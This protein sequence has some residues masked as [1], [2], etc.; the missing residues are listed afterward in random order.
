MKL[1][2]RQK[3]VDGELNHVLV[4][5]G[6]EFQRFTC[7][8]AALAALVMA[9]ACSGCQTMERHPVATAVVVGLAAGSI[10]ASTNHRTP[11]PTS[12]LCKAPLSCR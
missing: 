9:M 5:G 1:Q 11:A 7:L 8:K 3:I 10:A 2:V 4:V 12:D 6:Q